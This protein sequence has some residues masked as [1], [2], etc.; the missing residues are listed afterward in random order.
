MHEDSDGS[1]L[2]NHDSLDTL[3]ATMDNVISSKPLVP[4]EKFRD[5]RREQHRSLIRRFSKRRFG[6]GPDWGNA[7]GEFGFYG[8][9]ATMTSAPDPEFMI[10]GYLSI[11]KADKLFM[12][13]ISADQHVELELDRCI[14]LL[15]EG[16][17]RDLSQDE[18]MV[19]RCESHEPEGVYLACIE[20]EADA[21]TPEQL[22]KHAKEVDEAC[23]AELRKWTSLGALKIR[24]RL[25]SPNIM[26]SRWVIPVQED[27]RWLADHQVPSMHQGIQGRTDRDARHV[28]G[29][30]V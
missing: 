12:A 7:D 8:S 13:S 27:A 5:I 9:L 11:A 17:S 2:S 16:L 15:V 24:D 18:H 3:D 26:D 20:K 4:L 14:S 25:G 22:L 1:R 28:C 29:H 21:L 10:P 19:Y 23:L 30:G 6:Y